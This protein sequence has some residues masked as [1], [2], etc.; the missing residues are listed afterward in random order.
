MNTK[1]ARVLKS[2]SDRVPSALTSA[3][4]EE[5]P[6]TPAT[7]EAV[8]LA[9]D[10]PE[11][12]IKLRDRLILV[13]DSGLLN[14]TEL[15]VNPEIEKQIDEWFADEIKKEIALGRLPKP[16]KKEMGLEEFKKKSKQYVRRNSKR[17]NR[18]DKEG[19]VQTEGSPS[20]LSPQIRG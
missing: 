7:I 18:S 10:D 20:V 6:M 16:K 1:V 13:R 17:V 2:I 9:I 3:L 19:D 11:T 8:N 5:K 14:Q 15:V 4:M 12:P